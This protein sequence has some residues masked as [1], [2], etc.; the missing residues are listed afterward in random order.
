VSV[1]YIVTIIKS[2]LF[3]VLIDSFIIKL[4]KAY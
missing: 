1:Y 2:I 4:L 3:I